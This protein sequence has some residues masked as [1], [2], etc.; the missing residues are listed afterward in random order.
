ML[1]LFEYTLRKI[2]LDVADF[3]RK[4]LCKVL[5]KAT[6][7]TRVVFAVKQT[8]LL[9]KQPFVEARMVSI[10]VSVPQTLGHLKNKTNVYFLEK[11]ILLLVS[12][13]DENVA[14]LLRSLD[15]EER[16]TIL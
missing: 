13:L 15:G 11:Y 14:V 1:A 9:Y 5:R 6:D 8:L 3:G 12:V 16:L 2:K 10:L 4:E 7:Q